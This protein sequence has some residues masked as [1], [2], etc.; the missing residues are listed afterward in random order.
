MADYNLYGGFGDGGFNTEGHGGFSSDANGNSQRNQV[1]SNLTAV[2]IKQINDATQPIPDGEFKIHNVELNSVSFM[3]V[4]RRVDTQ[5]SAII[6][7]VEDGTGSI[8]VRKWIDD[9]LTTPAVETEKFEQQLNKYVYVG[10]SLKEF[11]GK[12]NIQNAYIYP[13]TDHNQILYHQLSA[14][15]THLRA[16]GVTSKSRQDDSGGLFVKENEATGGSISDQIL[17]VLKE[18]SSIMQEGVPLTYI[19]QKL[20]ITDDVGLKHC[21]ELIEA[22]KIYTGY[23][24]SSFLYMQF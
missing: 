14:I 23:D 16:Q 17:Q 13:V 18:N 4:V 20:N 24:D 5:A 22:G 11:G 3:G 6:I 19:T 1:R 8:E 21:H 10:G 7:T 12:K 9:N 15:S 2:T